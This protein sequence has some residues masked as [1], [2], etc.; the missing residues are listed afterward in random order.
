VRYLLRISIFSASFS[1]FTIVPESPTAAQ[2]LSWLTPPAVVSQYAGSTGFGS[3]GAGYDLFAG[4]GSLDLLYGYVPP[5]KGGSIHIGTI[6]FAYRPVHLPIGRFIDLRPVNPGLFITY[7][8]GKEYN[9]TWDNDY[10]PKGY[11]WWSP[12]ARIHLSLSSE[13]LFKYRRGVSADK[14]RA[15]IYT[16]FN[17]N[18]LYA[19]S[20]WLNK[21]TISFLDIVK[22]GI[23]VRIYF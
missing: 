2:D 11:Y 14:K 3:V 8:F 15:A 16:E 20:W 10:Y 23:G 12:A 13:V 9:L 5:S 17:T 22:M 6:K 4:N 21:K 19:V 1:L 18:D 7:H